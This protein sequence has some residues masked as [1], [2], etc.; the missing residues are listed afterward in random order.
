MSTEASQDEVGLSERNSALW[1]RER[2]IDASSRECSYAGKQT[3]RCEGASGN[4]RLAVFP[5]WRN[6]IVAWD[7]GKIMLR[8]SRFKC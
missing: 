4:T 6:T 5:R 3:I 7:G 2:R 1:W 8:P